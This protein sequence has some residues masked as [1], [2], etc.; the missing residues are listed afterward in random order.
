MKFFLSMLIL[1]SLVMLSAET[2][3]IN[4]SEFSLNYF[5]SGDE[6]I[7]E[8]TFGSFSRFPVEIN[9]EI[10]YRLDLNR[11]SSLTEKRISEIDRQSSRE[12]SDPGPA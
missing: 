12:R 8:L 10:Y 1:S 11:E 5:D 9:N 7:L 2:V 6:E 4:D 3:F